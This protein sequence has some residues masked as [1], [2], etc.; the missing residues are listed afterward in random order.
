MN[1]YKVGSKVNLVNEKETIFLDY[2]DVQNALTE[3]R[4]LY[5][6]RDLYK[7]QVKLLNDQSA[8]V[9]AKTTKQTP[10]KMKLPPAL[11]F[12]E[13]KRLQL[14]MAKGLLKQKNDLELFYLIL[15]C[16]CV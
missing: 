3:K 8:E 12:I 10:D 7:H 15:N 11:A 1:F 2:L 6:V 16:F 4:K 14:A 13:S 5:I 9:L